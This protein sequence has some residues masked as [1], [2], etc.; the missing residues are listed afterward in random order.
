MC[1]I[2]K[3]QENIPVCTLLMTA[4]VLLA[5]L[6]PSGPLLA[7]ELLDDN[8]SQFT[9]SRLFTQLQIGDEVNLAGTSRTINKLVIGL[10]QQGLH[11]TGDLQTRIY[12]NDGSGGLPATVSGNHLQLIDLTTRDTNNVVQIE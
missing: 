2:R 4:T 7:Q 9:G 12:A 11:G 1:I 3:N 6:L 5:T 8:T 10:S